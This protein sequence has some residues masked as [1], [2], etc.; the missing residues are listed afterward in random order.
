MADREPEPTAGTHSDAYAERLTRLGGKRWK[1]LL[2]V[3]APYRWNLRRLDLGF[4]L[5]VGCGLG[6]NLEHLGGNGV[7][8]DHNDACVAA[9]RARGLT[10]YGPA[11][12]EQSI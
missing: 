2:D 9:C 12:F 5:D 6:R 10:A 8:I 3:Q 4:T 1:R 11:E 7:G